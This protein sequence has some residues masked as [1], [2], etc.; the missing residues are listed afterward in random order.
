MD[1][2]FTVSL[3]GGEGG[4]GGTKN[5]YWKPSVTEPLLKEEKIGKAR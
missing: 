4:E 2:Q 3:G 1:L 5:L